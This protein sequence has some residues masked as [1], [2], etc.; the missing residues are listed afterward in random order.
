MSDILVKKFKTV[1]F[2]ETPLDQIKK[3][4]AEDYP[5]K[6]KLKPYGIAF[7]RD[8]LLEEGANPAVYLNAEGTK[9]RDYLISEFDK[10]FDG[11]DLYRKLR[12]QESFYKE[13]VQYYSLINIIREDHDFSWERE[14]RYHGDLNFKYSQIAAI[15]ASDPDDFE[16][17][18]EEKLSKTAMKY[19]KK[20]PIIDPEWNYEEVIEAISIKLWSLKT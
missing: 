4:I 18:C 14:W 17:K 1:C 10:H 13:I 11:T 15:I 20:T 6:I 2:T 8:N 7:W 12:E 9:L 3:L 5:R 19:I 16:D